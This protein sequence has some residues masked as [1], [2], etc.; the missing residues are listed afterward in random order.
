MG[1][2]FKKAKNLIKIKLRVNLSVLASFCVNL[3][4]VR[5]IWKE[6]ITMG[7]NAS[8]RLACWQACGNIFLSSD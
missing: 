6:E 3:A 1:Q 5:V 8:L 2:I 7:K 4:Q